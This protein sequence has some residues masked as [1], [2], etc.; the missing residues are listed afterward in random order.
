MTDSEPDD[1]TRLIAGLSPQKRA[2]LA[3][4]NPLSFAQRR[5][6]FLNQLEPGSS[7]YNLPAAM[8]LTGRLDFRAFERSLDEIIDRHEVLRT[9]FV[10][11]DDTPIQIISPSL[12]F[13]VPVIDL[14]ELPESAREHT[15]A[16]LV[17]EEARKPFDLECGPLLR[18]SMLK[19]GEAEHVALFTMHHIA[20]DGWSIGIIIRELSALYDAFSKGGSSPFEELPI[21]YADYARWQQEWLQGIEM[22]SQLD[23]WRQRLD[24][25]Q[26]MLELV[27]DR[28]RPPL[29]TFNGRR[30][31]YSLSQDL[32]QPIAALSRSEGVT[33]FTI[34][35]AAFQALLHRYT[36]QEDISLGSPIANRS[37]VE[38][39]PLI[40]CFVNT[41]VLRADLSG[42][43]TFRELLGRARK[44]VL[45]A[46]THQ[47]LPFEKLVEELQPARDLSHSPFFQ[48]MFDLQNIPIQSLE[49]SD[50][51]IAPLEMTGETEKFDLSLTLVETQQG[52]VASIG[53][54]TDLFNGDTAERMLEHY[55]ALLE[56]AVADPSSR[57]WD[58]NL[59]KPA[60]RR[61]T[62][63]EW[64]NTSREYGGESLLH[65]LFEQQAMLS[66]GSPAV[67]FDLERLSYAELNHRSNRLAR[68]LQMNG[69]GPEIQVGMCVERSIDMVVGLLAIL[70][71]GGV[72]VPL[73]PTFPARRLAYMIESSRLSIIL[74][75][76]RLKEVLPSRAANVICLDQDDHVINEQSSENLAAPLS[77]DN[78]ALVIYT[79]GST[80]DP[81]GV[82]LT[83][84]GLCNRLLWERQ[85]NPLNSSDAVLQTSS[86][87]FDISLWEIFNPL[88][89]GARLILAPPYWYQDRSALLKLIERE[90]VTVL[91]FVPST[92]QVLIEE[93]EFR[94]QKSLRRVLCGGEAMPLE[95]QERFLS[96][97]DAELHNSYGPTESSI[98]STFWKC[99]AG[100][101]ARSVP[102]GSPIANTRIYILDRE[103]QPVP[104]GVPGELHI[105]GAGLARGYL[106]LPELTA[107]KF[108]PDALSE[109][110]GSRL[111]CTGDLARLLADGSVEF[112]GRTD[113]QVKIRGFRIETGEI[114]A[115]LIQNPAVGEAVAVAREDTPGDKRLVAYVVPAQSHNPT[116]SELRLYLR[117]QLPDYMVPSVVILLE[118]FPRTPNGKLDRKS[119]PAPDRA[120]PRLEEVFVPPSSPAEEIVAGIWAEMLGLDQVGA[121]DNFF[122]LG[123]HSLLAVRIQSRLSKEFQRQIPLLRLFQYPT[124][125][126]LAQFLNEEPQSHSPGLEQNQGWADR[127]KEA[128]RRQRRK[129]SVA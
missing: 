7:A 20:G 24:G 119:L 42:N 112:L 22:K 51:K 108:I 23:Y 93:E 86:L 15:V 59:M 85:T 110:A 17:A 125:S 60:E 37:R 56:S 111:Y 35:L 70:K 28:P 118:S 68:Y 62:V 1:F 102:I 95:L 77:P 53:Y 18:A 2:L 31:Y 105:G 114:E 11:L 27:T 126:A 127:R 100:S 113:H 65:S 47:E 64:N 78:M 39:E 71:A 12:R 9:R 49:L 81:K 79:S 90:A 73:D 45:E 54:N 44:V 103:R 88:L 89:S 50:L 55:E 25:S 75:Q 67:A 99:E 4:R 123:G 33:L 101:G 117:E 87:S 21:Q 80:G 97:M 91:S 14:S 8:R 104:V 38:T 30:C 69:A 129:R 83:H 6:W 107:E 26:P 3:L 52:L 116:V 66:P 92:L 115:A 74:T 36:G 120:R 58:L 16:R 5:L 124:V 41:L 43:P 128:L 19:L 29:H 98:D 40:G 61:Q 76:Q 32:T 46:L 94:Q 84:R 13:R 96:V 57:V 63:F 10:M 121:Q 109:T 106:G 72:Y 82:M 122:D 34:L 48:V